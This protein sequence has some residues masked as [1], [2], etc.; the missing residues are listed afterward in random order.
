MAP[1]M[2][3][4]YVAGLIPS[5]LVTGAHLLLFRKKINS[6]AVHQLQA[7]LRLVGMYWSE[8]GACIRTLAEGT[9][10][11][12]DRIYL[13]GLKILGLACFFLSWIG[14]FFHLLI[15]LSLRYLAVP[16]IERA[17]LSSGLVRRTLTGAEV[18]DV[19]AEIQAR[20]LNAK[21]PGFGN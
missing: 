11:T 12:D 9:P 21:I 4:A 14:M 13:K 3:A 2:A 20:V 17:I 16:R 5:T 10:S 8:S 18:M 6:P 1:E 15:L 19:L 7:N